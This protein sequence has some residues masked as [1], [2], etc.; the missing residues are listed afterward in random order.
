M[1]ILTKELKQFSNNNEEWLKCFQDYYAQASKEDGKG[2]FGSFD[3]SLSLDEKR[4]KIDDV[5]FQEIVR[6]SGVSNQGIEH[7]VWMANPNVKWAFLAVTEA[8][9]EAVLPM[10]INRSIGLY[11]D[12]R[13]VSYGDIVKF[14]IPPR[15]LFTVSLGGH[16]ERT[17]N[18][19]KQFDADILVAPIEHLITTYVDMYK[20]LARTES[21]AEAVRRV[22][23]SI[24]TAMSIDATKALTTGMAAGTYP[25]AFS[26]VGQ[27]DVKQLLTIAE[28]VQAYN[29]GIKPIIA[30]PATA[31][32]QILPDSTTGGRIIVQGDQGSL[33]YMK[34]FY[35]F[36]LMML[37]QV[38]T[39]DFTNFGLALDPNTLYVL[40]PSVGRLIKGV[41]SNTLTNSNQFYDN[42]DLTSNFTYRKDFDFRFLSGAWGGMY[43]ITD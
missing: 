4:A 31:L 5:A 40:A 33:T 39:G 21:L 14:R 26:Y 22:V 30:G 32:S 34:N 28:T 24:D 42:A 20:V 15:T 36:D 27:F 13:Y 35:G 1:P 2:D 3:S 41:V 18:R 6:R 37:P 25:A 43:K 10:T 11:T 8:M 9:I 19:Q 17:T 29:Y 38:A 7:S 12:L 23:I 16:G